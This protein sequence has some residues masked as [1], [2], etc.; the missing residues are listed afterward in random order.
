MSTVLTIVLTFVATFMVMV[1][2]AT[3]VTQAVKVVARWQ[4]GENYGFEFQFA[5]FMA[6]E[7]T[8]AILL[9]KAAY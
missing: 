9:Y 4:R 5:V 1:A 3:L 8:V 6:V 2:L 7:L